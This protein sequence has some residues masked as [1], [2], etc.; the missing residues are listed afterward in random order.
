[1]DQRDWI[2]L[3]LGAGVSFLIFSTLGREMMMTGI[4]VTKAETRR[5][6]SKIEKKSKERELKAK[7]ETKEALAKYD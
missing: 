3:G 6:L 5:I 2:M 4:G 1:M 7:K